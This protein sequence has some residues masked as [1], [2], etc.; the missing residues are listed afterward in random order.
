[1]H[2]LTSTFEEQ[3]RELTTRKHSAGAE[4]WKRRRHLL[5]TRDLT[6][7]ELRCFLDV[8]RVCKESHES[9]A[10]LAV[11]RGKTIANIFYENSTRT[12]S[13][14]EVAARQLGADV[15]NLDTKV[16]SV[17][18]GETIVDT[19][20]QLVAMRVAAIVQRHSSSGSAHLLVRELGERVQVLN[21]GD[22]WNAH[23]TQGL[24]DLLTMTEIHP[25]LAGL[26]VA[27]VGDITHSRVARSD[28]W[29]LQSFGANIH[30]A[31]PPTLVPPELSKLGVVVHNQLEPA[32]ENADFIIML[33]LQLER[34]TQGL[35]PSIGEYKRLF[36]LD[37]SKLKL[38]S[39]EVRVLH[40]GPVNRGIE[41]TD[42][43]VDDPYY[44]LITT[45]V[46]NGVAARMAALYLLLA[47]HN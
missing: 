26:K 37:H 24:L 9:G 2:D 47:D 16:S 28:I 35:I 3:L 13:S 33:R 27:I 30:I 40:P 10:P 20:R 12:R 44:S 4:A 6:P 18:K 21:A 39:P 29:L 7:D 34:Q 25:Q 8:A 31:G 41:I 17:T 36:R 45:Q 15:L 1:M 38:A 22:G 11:L 43:L 46:T 14:F 32:I 23:P 5:E 19:A 42:E